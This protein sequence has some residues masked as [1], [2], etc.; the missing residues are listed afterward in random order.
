V[1]EIES[2]DK[3]VNLKNK[4]KVEIFKELTFNNAIRHNLTHNNIGNGIYL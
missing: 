1:L 2:F 3:M 4:N